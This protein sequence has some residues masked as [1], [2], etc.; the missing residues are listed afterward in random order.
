MPS[1][2][3]T[4]A[5]I[6][7]T[8][9]AGWSIPGG[10]EGRSARA[11]SADEYLVTR[12]VLTGVPTAVAAWSDGNA[13]LDPFDIV[14]AAVPFRRLSDSGNGRLWVAPDD[15]REEL[16]RVAPRGRYDAVLVIWPSDGQV[17]L[18][19]WG[20]SWGPSDDANGA[21]FSSIVSDHWGRYATL[22]HPEEGFVHEWLHQVEATFRSLGFGED[23]FPPL[24]DAETLT[25]CRPADEPPFGGTYRQYQDGAPIGNTWQPWYHDYLTGRVR[26]PSGDGCFGLTPEIW[27][28][29]RGGRRRRR[30]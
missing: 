18:C 6:Y 26:R 16:D 10:A 19:G 27:R 1:T 4:L 2:W 22:P 25:S 23:A 21:D 5:L 24:H 28:H 30:I 29:W 17:P 15:C 11:M 9:D 8:A 14:D 12:D 20:C 13:A 7:R 3:R